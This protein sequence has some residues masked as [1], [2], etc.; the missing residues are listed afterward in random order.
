MIFTRIQFNYAF[1]IRA[2]VKTNANKG[3]D[4]G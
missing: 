3:I 1:G 2:I 4:T